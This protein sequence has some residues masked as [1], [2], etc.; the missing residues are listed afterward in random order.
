M[1]E[2]RTVYKILIGKS[3]EKRSLGKPRR[4][5]EDNIRVDL[6]GIVS[7]DVDGI[8]QDREQRRGLVSKTISALHRA[9]KP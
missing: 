3:E 7:E 6:K 5:W 2:V 4:R 1:R 8:L 9:S